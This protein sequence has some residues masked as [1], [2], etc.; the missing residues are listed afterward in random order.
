MAGSQMS[1]T[2]VARSELQWGCIL[3]LV[4]RL[5][6]MVGAFEIAQSVTT[7]A[8]ADVISDLNSDVPSTVGF[9]TDYT[10]NIGTNNSFSGGVV[11]YSI[12]N[13]ASI[14]TGSFSRI[15]YFLE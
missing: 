8:R 1:R 9:Q 3:K 12:D 11:P 13:S 6:L 10:L 15:G 4:S 5:A 2:S 7:L 14:A